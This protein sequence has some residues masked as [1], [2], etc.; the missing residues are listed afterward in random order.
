[1][2]GAYYANP[3]L[4]GEPAFTRRDVRIAFDWG[5]VRPVGGSTAEPYRSFPTDGFSVRWTGRVVPRFSEPYQLVGEADDGVRIKL[6]KPGELA[7]KTLVDRWTEPGAFASEPVE[8]AGG[9]LYEIEIEY[10]ETGGKARCIVA[11]QSPST[12]REVVDPVVQQGLNAASF[13]PFVWADAM[14][15]ARY[16]EKIETVDE[17][18]WPTQNGT[19]L[20]MSESG[21]SE[22]ELS[23]TYSLHFEGKAQVRESCCTDLTFEAGGTK[24]G[25]TLPAGAGY[26]PKT[27][28]TAATFRTT[29]SRSMFFFEDTSREGGTKEQ[30]VTGI[31]LMR[32]LEPGSDRSHGP[33]EVVYRPFKSVLQEAFTTI[34]WLE[35]AN[36]EGEAEWSSRGLPSDA[37]FRDASWVENW[38]YLV[39]L[40][41]ETGN[42]LYITTPVAANDEYFRKLALLLRYGSDGREPYLDRTAN[43]V[44]P[45]LNPNLRVYI[46]VGNEIWNWV[47]PSTQVVQRL[48]AAEAASDSATWAE[49]NYDGTAGNPTVA[50]SDAFRSVWGDDAM[51]SSV[52]VLIGYQ[53]DNYQDTATD[54]LTFIDG[55]YGNPVD[56]NGKEAHPVSY[57]VWGGGAASYY[58]LENKTGSQTHSVLRDPSFEQPAIALNTRKLRPSGSPW[59]FRGSAGVFRPGSDD[60]IQGFERLVEPTSGQQ[61]AFITGTGSISQRVRFAKTGVYAVTFHAAGHREGWPPHLAF[62]IY[63]DDIRLT[64]LDQ[65]DLRPADDPMELTG[66]SRSVETFEAQWGSLVFRV[67]Q[68]GER[69]I[70]FVGEGGDGYLFL[71]DVEI[72]SVD[73]MFD[74]GFRGGE[75]L[76]EVSGANLAKEFRSRAK[77][78]RTFGLQVVAYE[79][80]WSV[81]GDFGQLPIQNWSKLKDD[82]AKEVNDRMVQLWDE[83]G[84]FMNI[85]GV[86]E[87]WPRYD[88]VNSVTY[89]LMRSLKF[90]SE[91]LRAEATF[92]KVLPALLRPK[93]ADW[94]H[95][96]EG[97]ASWLC[98]YLPW[99]DKRGDRAWFSWMLIAPATGD[100]SI[101]VRAKGEGSLSVEVDGEAAIGFAEVKAPVVTPAVR[102]TKGAHAVRVVTTGDVEV[103]SVQIGD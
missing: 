6:R 58:G 16:G 73:A 101:R 32:P 5:N 65:T 60:P 12:P 45:P 83:S 88:L 79:A 66:W 48:V 71:E 50:C 3:D 77:Y 38:E 80:G 62:N 28:T 63:V 21:S 25:N 37:F 78:A 18:G 1:M 44:Y 94:T 102:L 30:G 20:I 84:S 74:G 46:E 59:T 7:W 9:Q 8:L 86:F 36:K 51:G 75:A 67:D 93:D 2:L 17:H 64:P 97:E 35:G 13:A 87:F 24:Y 69:T 54:S 19:E 68:P 42:D 47:F 90:S 10:R 26:D 92:G 33:T 4:E 61:A 55:Y 82:R 98:R 27:N 23:G 57:Y 34:R 85:W 89:P 41:N 56:A 103:Q 95:V 100:Y 70:R 22:P 91:R 11:W 14:R 43:P 31:Q 49:L 99:R 40:S 53:Y 76:G 81:G 39:M 96:S 15:S 29:G 72:S 52:R